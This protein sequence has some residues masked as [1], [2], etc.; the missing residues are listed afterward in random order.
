MTPC[1]CCRWCHYNPDRGRLWCHRHDHDVRQLCD[2][3]E[4]EAG[5]DG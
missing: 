1:F 4:R 5:A 3:Y 2:D